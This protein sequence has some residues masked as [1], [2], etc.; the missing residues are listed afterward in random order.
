MSNLKNQLIRLG[1]AQPALRR[2]IKPVIASL[3]GASSRRTAGRLGLRPRL[4]VEDLLDQECTV[5]AEAYMKDGGTLDLIMSE[6]HKALNPL[7]QSVEHALRSH[8]ESRDIGFM[9]DT[10]YPVLMLDGRGAT[11]SLRLW[12]HFDGSNLDFEEVREYLDERF[13]LR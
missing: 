8:P 7:I 13:D 1:N 10:E 4:V 3:G 9:R 6:A 12:V 5:T 2:H 11:L